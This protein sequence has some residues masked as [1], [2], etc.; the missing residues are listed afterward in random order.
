MESDVVVRRSA[1][2][3]GSVVL[4]AVTGA[5]L[6]LAATPPLAAVD[7]GPRSVNSESRQMDFWLGDWTVT[8][9]GMLG[10]AVSKVS[11]D[12]DKCL[13]VESWDG[14]KGHSGQNMFAYSSDDKSW[15]GMFAD[16]QGR[17]HILEGKVAAGAAE[18]TGSSTGPNGQTVL[19]RIKVTRLTVNKVEQSW[20]K[21]TDNGVTWKME[22]RGEYS[23]NNP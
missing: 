16:N 3:F 6:F 23:R 14:G 20:E 1:R 10:S 12:L 2:W 9:P 15:H 19:N 7:S 18:F 22:F 11:L 4:L 8:Y 21:S 13:L 17:V 5:W